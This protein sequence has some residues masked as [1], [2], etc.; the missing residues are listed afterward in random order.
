MGSER[1]ILL[2]GFEVT[3]EKCLNKQWRTLRDSV[4]SLICN[5]CGQVVQKPH[6][7]DQLIFRYRAS[8]TLLRAVNSDVLPCILSLRYL[9]R[10]A[11]GSNGL[12]FGS[13]PG[14]DVTRKSD[15]GRIGEADVAVLLNDGRWIV[16]ECK[17]TALGLNDAELDKLWKLAE[18]VD[19]AATFV[20]TLDPSQ[21]CGEIWHRTNGWNDRP[22]FALTAEHLYD[23][24][25]LRLYGNDP[26]AWR[27]EYYQMGQ[28]GASEASLGTRFEEYLA[29]IAENT[30]PDQR[31]RAPWMSA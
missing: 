9:S 20:A 31:N 11:Q 22:H 6:A 27:K 4:P 13:Y 26:F 1:G 30:D 28:P 25:G 14:V 8:E 17:T 12:F 2:T 16:G 24:D 29:R 10:L 3:C 7:I 19:A 21:A 15:G 5:G 18:G 23:L